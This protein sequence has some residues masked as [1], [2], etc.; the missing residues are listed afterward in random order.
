[1]FAESATGKG[2]LPKYGNGFEGEGC[3]ELLLKLKA[4]QEQCTNSLNAMF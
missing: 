3:V 2:G 1:M 4:A